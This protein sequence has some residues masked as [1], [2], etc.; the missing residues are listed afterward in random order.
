MCVRV[1]TVDF[2]DISLQKYDQV[3]TY[4][5]SCSSSDVI[6]IYNIYRGLGKMSKIHL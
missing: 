4:S 3:I 1:V 6:Y 5:L 2:D